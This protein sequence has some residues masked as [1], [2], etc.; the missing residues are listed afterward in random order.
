MGVI[1]LKK[2]LR[3]SA[4]VAQK[5]T[6]AAYGRTW[7][8][9]A[10]ARA[11]IQRKRRAN[12]A[13]YYA[14]PSGKRTTLAQWI[15]YQ[16]AVGVHGRGPKK[17]GILSVTTTKT[18]SGKRERRLP[19]AGRLNL[20]RCRLQGDLEARDLFAGL[21]GL[22]AGLP[23]GLAGVEP[24]LIL[25]AYL[26]NVCTHMAIGNPNGN[27]AGTGGPVGAAI[28]V[29]MA[30]EVTKCLEELDAASAIR[31]AL[32]ESGTVKKAFMLSSMDECAA[33]NLL[34]AMRYTLANTEVIEDEEGALYLQYSLTNPVSGAEIFINRDR[35]WARG[36]YD[37]E[38]GG[39]GGS[40][41][42]RDFN[43]D[44]HLPHGGLQVEGGTLGLALG[45]LGGAGLGSLQLEGRALGLA[46]RLARGA[47]LGGLEL[48]GGAGLGG[49]GLGLGG[50]GAGGACAARA[51][52]DTYWT[53]GAGAA[54]LG[55]CILQSPRVADVKRWPSG[56]IEHICKRVTEDCPYFLKLLQ[57]GPR[58]LP[59]GIVIVGV[60][61]DELRMTPLMPVRLSAIGV[62]GEANGD[63]VVVAAFP[64]RERR[65]VR[66]E[67]GRFI[68]RGGAG[69]GEGEGGSEGGPKPPKKARA[70]KG[71]ADPASDEASSPKKAHKAAADSSPAAPTLAAGPP[72]FN[73]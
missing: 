41:Y 22:G 17:A 46:L 18:T 9:T 37:P 14:Y 68:L 32:V 23:P 27:G 12:G 63:R 38:Q 58:M 36:A 67:K 4:I 2:G 16:N 3:Q 44:P 6:K 54:G 62:P 7:T 43:L 28:N 40:E 64:G 1:G 50:L 49:L 33:K 20:H 66:D 30:R 5:P 15:R 65:V 45:L 60:P 42:L 71:A 19:L 13:T 48:E 8:V 70:R 29:P 53:A 47:G 51:S 73:I 34:S 39:N 59:R 69:A 55:G 24:Q 25:Y 11:P 21:A 57:T 52:R 35:I 10:A 72:S 26:C 31:V 56:M 61:E